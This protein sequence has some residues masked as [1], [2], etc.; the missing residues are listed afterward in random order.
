MLTYLRQSTPLTI[1]KHHQ[2]THHSVLPSSV[3]EVM[4]LPTP[5]LEKLRAT[6]A[7]PKLPDSD[8]P[9][10]KQALKE[11]KS[12]VKQLTAV[13]SRGVDDAIKSVH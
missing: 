5:H 10:I 3:D 6:L 2:F 11:Y 4:E 13:E 8:G 12:W 7:N 9:R 1:L